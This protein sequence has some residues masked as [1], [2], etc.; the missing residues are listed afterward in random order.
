MHCFFSVS[1]LHV[2]LQDPGRDPG[3]VLLRLHRHPDPGGVA[4]H[5]IRR[6]ESL[7]GESAFVVSGI[8]G[9]LCVFFSD[10]FDSF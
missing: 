6:E 2:G 3:L 7:S 1:G 5:K 8:Q 10:S 9:R 4:R